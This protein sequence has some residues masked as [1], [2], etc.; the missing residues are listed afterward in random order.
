MPLLK[1]LHKIVKEQGS[2]QKEETFR[3]QRELKGLVDAKKQIL[4][5]I[6]KC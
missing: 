2:L 4:E 1:G 3:L 5:G 6:F